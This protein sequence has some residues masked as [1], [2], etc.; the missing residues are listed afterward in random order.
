[1][2]QRAMRVWVGGCRPFEGVGG[3]RPAGTARPRV[4]GGPRVVVGRHTATDGRKRFAATALYDAD[5]EPVA[6]SEAVW[7]ALTP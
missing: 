3:P 6:W 5:G 2:I 7:I 4:R 1:M